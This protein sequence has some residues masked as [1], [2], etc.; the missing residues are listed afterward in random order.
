MI[1]SLH[2]C[3][4]FVFVTLVCRQY[5]WWNKKTKK[6]QQKS[7]RKAFNS[8]LKYVTVYFHL[9]FLPFFYRKSVKLKV[10]LITFVQFSFF[11]LFWNVL[12]Y[13]FLLLFI[14]INCEQNILRF[15]VN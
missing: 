9:I 3:C 6:K 8:I 4:L 5:L 13:I 7:A 12:R 2:Y 11:F 1:Y 15:V 14:S 10:I